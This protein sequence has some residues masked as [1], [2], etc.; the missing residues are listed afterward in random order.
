MASFL[1]LSYLLILGAALLFINTPIV[2]V[3]NCS[4]F[5]CTP[6]YAPSS[7]AIILIRKKELVALLSLS[8]W[9]LMIVVCLFLAVQ[10][11]CLQF[12]IVVFPDQTHLLFLYCYSFLVACSCKCI[13]CLHLSVIAFVFQEFLNFIIMTQI[14]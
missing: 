5:C 2:G 4:M 6:R 14:I 3:C 13:L 9:C 11:V 7:F 12:V 1:T 10:W 8:F